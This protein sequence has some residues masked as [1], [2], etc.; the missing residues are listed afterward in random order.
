M[1][2]E[3]RLQLRIF[4]RRLRG[5]LDIRQQLLGAYCF[6]A[7]ARRASAVPSVFGRNRVLFQLQLFHLYRYSFS[8]AMAG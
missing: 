7:W 6:H 8:I 5:R 1:R 4:G 3:H 2:F